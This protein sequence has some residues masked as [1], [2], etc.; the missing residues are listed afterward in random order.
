MK[1]HI[2]SVHKIMSPGIKVFKCSIKNCKFVT[3]S[4][5]MFARHNHDSSKAKTDITK[6][7]CADC[8]EM[9]ANC[10]SLKRHVR[11]VHRHTV[12]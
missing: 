3:G 1:Q 6:P 9:F 5:V 10:S 7:V 11:R 12:G 8:Q 2:I 4:R